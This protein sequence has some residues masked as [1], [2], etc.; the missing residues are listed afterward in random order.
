ME[1]KKDND[2][3][4]DENK[5]IT[6]KAEKESSTNNY[7][8]FVKNFKQS[9]QTYLSKSKDLFYGENVKG[10]EDTYYWVMLT[11][12]GELSVSTTT[13]NKEEYKVADKVILYKIVHIGNGG[14]KYLCYVTEDGAAYV[15]NT[16][17]A[18]FYKKTINSK[19]QTKAKEIVDIISVSMED[20]MEAAFVDIDG[21]IYPFEYT[22]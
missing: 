6:E 8:L 19:K 1:L 4:V 15:A 11:K 7:S 12:D 17:E 22:E 3:L 16:D 9:T 5:S 21:N 14:F 10:L 18:M 2:K 20:G 13:S